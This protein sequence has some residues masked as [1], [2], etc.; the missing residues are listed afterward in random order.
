MKN[1]SKCIFE[2]KASMCSSKNTYTNFQIFFS[3]LQP[4]CR[5]ISHFFSLPSNKN[6]CV[7]FERRKM[8]SISAYTSMQHTY[9]CKLYAVE[10]NFSLPAFPR[11]FSFN[12]STCCFHSHIYTSQCIQSVY[13]RWR[14]RR[15]HVHVS[16]SHSHS[17][18]H[19]KL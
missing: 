18:T 12:S 7:Y 16:L 19:K 15:R 6:T 3:S 10:K 5:Y 14:R 4:H 8:K 1:I 13:V 17:H 11:E 2:E 9:M